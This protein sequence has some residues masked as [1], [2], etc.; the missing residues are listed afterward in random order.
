MT[1]R[2]SLNFELWFMSPYLERGNTIRQ[3][4]LMVNIKEAIYVWILELSLLCNKCLMRA[5]CFCSVA[6]AQ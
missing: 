5:T 6:V 4:G 2:Q 3:H 1:C